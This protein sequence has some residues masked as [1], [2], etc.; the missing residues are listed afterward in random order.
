LVVRIRI[1]P[2]RIISYSW[3]L[4]LLVITGDGILINC[5]APVG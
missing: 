4:E 1:F 2:G 3:V 5:L